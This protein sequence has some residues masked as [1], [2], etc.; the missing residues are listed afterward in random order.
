MK[1]ENHPDALRYQ[2]DYEAMLRDIGAK[3]E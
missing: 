1:G 2:G 3:A